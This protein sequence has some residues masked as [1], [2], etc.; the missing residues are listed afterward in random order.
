[1]VTGRSMPRV[2]PPRSPSDFEEMLWALGYYRILA[3][4]EVGRGAVAGPITAAGV[5]C[6]SSLLNH[7]WLDRVRDSKKLS[8]RVRQMLVTEVD[9]ACIRYFVADASWR[10]IDERGIEMAWQLAID[11]VLR[12]CRL[13]GG[14]DFILIDG[15]RCP[16]CQRYTD[17]PWRA[18][19][20]GDDLHVS[21]S[22]ASVI[23]KVSRDNQMREHH[24]SWPVY[25][26][27]SNKGYLTDAHLQALELHGL[28]PLHRR[29]WPAVMRAVHKTDAI[30]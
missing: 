9:L 30:C 17:T 7:P 5:I 4:D 27:T 3:I 25:N 2:Y 23:A 10:T 22:L 26:F 13:A 28:S 19:T 14:C 24:K 8:A 16:P 15:P 11:D 6:T 12:Q 21:I 29:S 18:A 1:L 20:H